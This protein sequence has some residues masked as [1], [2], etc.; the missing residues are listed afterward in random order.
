L[1]KILVN[2]LLLNAKRLRIGGARFVNRAELI[3]IEP[4]APSWAYGALYMPTG[5][6]TSPYKMTVALAE[7]AVSN[8]AQVCLNTAVLGM[9]TE[10]GRIRSVQ[11]NRGTIYPKIV[12]NASGVYADVIAEMAGDRTFTIHR[13][14]GDGHYPR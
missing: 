5:G 10:G 8:G 11:T 6:F 1:E 12:I 13:R 7:N 2:V 9:E 4:Y 3:K 14:K